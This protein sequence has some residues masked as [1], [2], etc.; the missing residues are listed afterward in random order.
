MIKYSK[1]AY[2]T[3]SEKMGEAKLWNNKLNKG[4][5]NGQGIVPIHPPG[6]DTT[7][8]NSGQIS[9]FSSRFWIDL[10]CDPKAIED[11]FV[12]IDCWS[13]K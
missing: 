12:L 2:R 8:L 6:L 1:S 3:A 13:V 10:N 7:Q 9:T 4:D 11:W 5:P